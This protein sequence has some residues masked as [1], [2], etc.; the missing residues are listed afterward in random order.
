[1]EI[2]NVDAPDLPSDSEIEESFKE[3]DPENF[4]IEELESLLNRCIENE[5]YEEAARI[6]AIIASKKR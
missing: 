4:S 3:P 2:K 6:K 5:E 1:M